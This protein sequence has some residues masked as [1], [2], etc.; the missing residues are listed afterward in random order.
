METGIIKTVII[1][2]GKILPWFACWIVLAFLS[3][4]SFIKEKVQF[5]LFWTVVGNALA[6][7]LDVWHT[8]LYKECKNRE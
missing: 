7:L 4:T 3:D 6:A 8:A 5:I 2:V 1:N